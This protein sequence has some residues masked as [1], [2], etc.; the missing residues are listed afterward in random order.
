MD[1]EGVVSV[2][3]VFQHQHPVAVKHGES[4]PEDVV[5]LEHFRRNV[6][7]G[8]HRL[9]FAHPHK[10]HSFDGRGGE[11]PSL[12]S[13]RVDHLGVRPLG[14]EGHTI[15]V[16]IEGCPV[17]GTGQ[18]PLE[19]AASHREVYCPMG[20]PVQQSL[21]LSLFVPEEDHVGAQHTQHLGLVL[22]HVLG[23]QGRIPVLP[24]PGRR[25][26]A[27]AVLGVVGRLKGWRLVYA[28]GAAAHVLVAAGVAGQGLGQ[29]FSQ[30][31]DC[32][33]FSVVMNFFPC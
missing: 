22:L 9:A 23:R 16:A 10:D 8:V 14:E 1:H 19:V 26:A 24:E 3:G 11:L 18:V 25:Y 20:A 2:H 13:R 21:H 33:P 7:L 28:L 30:T 12:H 6:L 29:K 32:Y 17:I 27:A 5:L 31:H 15:A 4:R